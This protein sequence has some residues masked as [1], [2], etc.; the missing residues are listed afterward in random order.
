MNRVLS[1]LCTAS[2]M[3]IAAASAQAATLKL[4]GVSGIWTAATPNAG[5]TLTGL[6]SASL[7]WG[8][9]NPSPGPQSGYDF[10]AP[11]DLPKDYAPGVV[12]DLGT[13]THL[14][15]P[16][17][18]GTSITAAT[19]AVTYSFSLDGSPIEVRT[20]EFKFVHNETPNNDNLCAN[21]ESNNQGINSNGCADSVKATLNL[22]NSEAIKIGADNYYLSVTGFLFNGDLLSEFWTQEGASTSAVLQASF[23][24]EKDI[25]QP[26]PI[27]LPAAG[28]LLLGALGALAFH[29]KSA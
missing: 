26:A 22:G 18:S 11:S 12:F 17:N 25:P 23:M 29:R 6:N 19:L 16:I 2:A 4:E 1:M 21:G 28:F 5:G 7:R 15:Y 13:F 14:N 20:S 27:P 8:T 9:P 3:T 24:H 10:V